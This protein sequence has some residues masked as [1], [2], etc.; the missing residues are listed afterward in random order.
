MGFFSPNFEKEGIGIE[1][2]EIIEYNFIYF[3]KLL[4]EKFWIIIKLNFLF[5]IFSIPIITLPASLGALNSLTM[6]IV[7]RKHVFIWSDFV[8]KFKEN[9]KQ[10]TIC[11]LIFTSLMAFSVFCLNLYLNM[12]Q[13]NQLFIIFFFITL[14]IMFFL[15][16]ISL[17][18]YPL[19]TTI[20]LSIKN[21]I[22]N[23]I[24][25][26]V[27]CIKTSLL[28][29]IV[30]LFFILN[31]IAFFPFTLPLILIMGFSILSF[32]NSF[33]TFKCIDKYIA[34]H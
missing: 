24:L 8:S 26:S 14:T 1:K 13:I 15:I 20:S 5:I 2:Q 23:S 21:I 7:Q 31:F 32:I 4:I 34:L 27:V 17:Y 30:F 33:I 10:S 3:F 25:L 12:S 19:I 18:V 9:W 11:F 28:G 29:L 6:L 22:K 16:M